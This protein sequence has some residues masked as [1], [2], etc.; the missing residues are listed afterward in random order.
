VTRD[1]GDDVAFDVAVRHGLDE[2][3]LADV[4]G[5]SRTEVRVRRLRAVADVSLA[6]LRPVRAAPAW[7]RERTLDRL[8]ER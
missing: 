3:E 7:L 4:F 1:D 5:I 6:C 2:G 8:D